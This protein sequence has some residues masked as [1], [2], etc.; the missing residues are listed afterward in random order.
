MSNVNPFPGIGPLLTGN[1]PADALFIVFDRIAGLADVVRTIGD[2]FPCK[3]FRAA[4]LYAMSAAL[5][6]FV[7]AAE[8]LNHQV[9]G[10]LNHL[11]NRRSK[12][13]RNL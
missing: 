5:E 10:K 9:C 2:S 4:Q 7:R 6:G 13:E 1:H 12:A 3:D 11:K 8:W